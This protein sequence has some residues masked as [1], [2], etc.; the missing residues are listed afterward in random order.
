MKA[1]SPSQSTTSI[2]KVKHAMRSAGIEFMEI[3]DYMVITKNG[4]LV[5]FNPMTS[6]D[7][8]ILLA[9]L[10]GLSIRRATFM[11]DRLIGFY[12]SYEINQWHNFICEGAIKACSVKERFITRKSIVEFI[13]R[14]CVNKAKSDEEC[15]IHKHTLELFI[16]LSRG[17]L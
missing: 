17:L 9:K 1:N 10:A 14:F 7:D 16:S 2:D 4:R 3:D 5:S 15:G 6:D 8:A 11:S 12:F 13:H